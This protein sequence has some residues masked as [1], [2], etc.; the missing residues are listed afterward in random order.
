[1]QQSPSLDEARLMLAAD[2][3]HMPAGLYRRASRRELIRVRPGVYASAEWWSGLR[4]HERYRQ[5]VAAAARVFPD[6]VFMSE[7]AASIHELPTFGEPRD[8]H[9]FDPD[10]RTTKRFG[11]VVVHATQ[12]PRDVVRIDSWCAT[13]LTATVVDTARH[14]PPAYALAVVDAALRRGLGRAHLRDWSLRDSNRRHERM[15]AWVWDFADPLAESAGES[16]SRAVISWLGFAVPVLQ[17]VFTF[18][19]ITDRSDFWWPH[20]RAIGESDGYGKYVALT[21]QAAVNRVVREKVRE[22]RLRRYSDGFARWDWADTH[23][24][25]P[26]ERKLLRAG[27]PL[28]ASRDNAMLATLRR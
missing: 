10:R 9:I 7:S 15:L 20:V 14:L 23:L 6:A 18:E 28:V 26:V 12:T 8:I 25:L 13:D 1:M 17:Q 3:R 21:A 4:P 19:G 22:D 5:R 2:E 16:V 27:V 24:V 11:D